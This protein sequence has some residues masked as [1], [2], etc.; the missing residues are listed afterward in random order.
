MFSDPCTRGVLPLDAFLE[1]YLPF[2]A[3]FDSFPCFDFTGCNDYSQSCIGCGCVLSEPY[4][5]F[6][7]RLIFYPPLS[8]SLSLRALLPLRFPPRFFHDFSFPFGRLVEGT[9]I[10]PSCG[11]VSFLRF[12]VAQLLLFL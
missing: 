6:R 11:S 12:V 4:C 3:E 7:F 8:C 2:L 9:V 5:F 10:S 1:S